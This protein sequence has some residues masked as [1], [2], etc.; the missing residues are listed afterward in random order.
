MRTDFS[1]RT[2][3]YYFAIKEHKI[4]IADRAET[5]GSMPPVHIVTTKRNT[6]FCCGAMYDNF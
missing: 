2:P 5:S 3:G 4:V 6:A 1:L